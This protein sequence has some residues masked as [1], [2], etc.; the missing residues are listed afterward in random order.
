MTDPRSLDY[1]PQDYRLQT[2]DRDSRTP[3]VIRHCESPSA[4]SRPS[5]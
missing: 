3:S 4:I 1:G 5:L 2:T